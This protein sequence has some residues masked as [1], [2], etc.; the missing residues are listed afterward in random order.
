MPP[1]PASI[2]AAPLQVFPMIPVLEEPVLPLSPAPLM[3]STSQFIEKFFGWNIK[4]IF[5][6][7]SADDHLWVCA[8]DVH[9][10]G[11]AELVEVVGAYDDV[12]V[13]RQKFVES[14]LIFD[15]VVNPWQVF[16]RPLHVGPKPGHAEASGAAF[17]EN[18]L[19]QRQHRILIEAAL[20]QIRV[21]PWPQLKLPVALGLLGVD[22]RFGK[23]SAPFR[24]V[25]VIDDLEQPIVGCFSG[26]REWQQELI[27]LVLVVEKRT[28]MTWTIKY[29]LSK[30]DRSQS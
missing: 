1:R 26:F 9:D 20:A 15:E 7:H 30:P 21:F 11:R 19:N 25:R 27:L 4:R 29:C 17:L 5:L 6:Q 2:A 10:D 13:I 12:I 14:G 28:G 8:H 18:V 3:I 22:A 23:P 16:E 24:Q